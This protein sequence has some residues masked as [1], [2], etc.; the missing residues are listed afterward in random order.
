M[1]IAM[2]LSMFYVWTPHD[3]L[4]RATN[5]PTNMSCSR[6]YI[7]YVATDTG[8]SVYYYH[9]YVESLLLIL[10]VF[11]LFTDLGQPKQERRE[12]KREKRREEKAE[13]RETEERSPTHPLHH[14]LPLSLLQDRLG[15]LLV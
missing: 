8:F 12:E 4:L 14:H 13:M 9:S 3:A 15:E 5:Q 1:A 7:V 10:P 11:L 6:H 2:I